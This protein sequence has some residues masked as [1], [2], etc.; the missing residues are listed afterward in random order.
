MINDC[1]KS[2]IN[3]YPSEAQSKFNQL[4]ELVFNV[5]ESNPAIGSINETVKWGE[6][7]YLTEK[8]RIGTTIRIV[9]KQKNKDFIGIYLNCK[10]T[11]VETIAT[12]FPDDFVVLGNR[13]LLIKLDDEIPYDAICFCF[14]MSLTYHLKKRNN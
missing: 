9:W 11:L 7:A 5:A 14:E 6:P 1:L 8:K 13:G 3:T 2:I 4:R 12:L 10:T